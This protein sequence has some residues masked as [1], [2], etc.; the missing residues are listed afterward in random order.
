MKGESEWFLWVR[1]REGAVQSEPPG[2]FLSGGFTRSSSVWA[3]SNHRC[4]HSCLHKLTHLAEDA[5]EQ[6]CRRNLVQGRKP[7]RRFRPLDLFSASDNRRH[8]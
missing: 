1:R 2:H 6:L 5:V 4:S 3:A 7:S 8:S